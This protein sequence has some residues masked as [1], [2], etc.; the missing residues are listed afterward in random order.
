MADLLTSGL[1]LLGLNTLTFGA[2]GL[3]KHRAR[4]GARRISERTL[5]A[6]ALLGGTPGAYAARR[7]FRHKTRKQP[8]SALLHLILAGQG[9]AVAAMLGG[10]LP[11]PL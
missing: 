11:R 7:A 4:S 9:L 1:A 3:D 2:F 8:F 5:L 10:F 6:L